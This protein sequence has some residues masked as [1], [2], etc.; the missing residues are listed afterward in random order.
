MQALLQCLNPKFHSPTY[1]YHGVKVDSMSNKS[2]VEQARDEIT[3]EAFDKVIL[4]GVNA[5]ITIHERMKG[6]SVER[7]TK[8]QRLDLRMTLEQLQHTC[9]ECLRDFSR[10]E[11]I[12]EKG[13]FPSLAP[14]KNPSFF[15]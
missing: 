7:L 8:D 1:K 12:L 14:K 5:K 10:E 3:K 11:E 2:L 6:I 9:E 4:I 13:Q 15:D